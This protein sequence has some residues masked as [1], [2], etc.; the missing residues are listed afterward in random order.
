M[1]K[2]A[3]IFLLMFSFFIIGCKNQE[4]P[5]DD[6]SV[7]VT[8]LVDIPDAKDDYKYIIYGSFSDWKASSDYYLKKDNDK[9]KIEIKMSKDTNI[10]YKYGLLDGEDIRSERDIDNKVINDRKITFDK[11]K[12]VNDTVEKFDGINVSTNKDI[13]DNS[14]YDNDRG[15]V[16]TIDLND[17]IMKVDYKKQENQSWA[18]VIRNFLNDETGKL[19]EIKIEFLGEKDTEYLFKLEGGD[20][21]QEVSIIGTGSKELITI[22]VNETAINSKKFVIFGNPGKT[23]TKEEP[24]SGHYEIH[25]IILT[26]KAPDLAPIYTP[27]D[28]P[29]HILA[30]GN[31]FSDDG[32][33]LLYDILRDLGY[34]DIIIGNLYIGGCTVSTHKNNLK[35]DLSAYTYRENR[36]GSWVNRDNYKASVALEK[37]KWDFISLQQASNYSGLTNYY[38]KNDIDYIYSTAYNIA[39]IKNE[40]VKFVWQ[41]TWAYQSDSNHSAFPNYGKDQMRMYNGIIN[42]VREVIETDDF[43]PIIVP[44]GTTIQNL[45]TTFLGDTI[46]RDGY[47]LNESFGRYSASLTWAIK[48]TGK[49]IDDVKAPKSVAQKLIPLCKEAAKNA[50]IKPYEV[51]ESIYKID[52]EKQNINLDNYVLLNPSEYI[53]GNGYYNSQDSTKFLTPIQDGS[54]FCNGF[55]TTKL[56]TP[57][58]L[59]VGTVIVLDKGYQYRPEGWI[60]EAKQQNRNGNTTEEMVIVTE[61]WWGSYIYRAFNLSKVGG[62]VLTGDNY[63]NAINSFKIYLP[64]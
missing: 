61:D 46:T 15:L 29:I 35:N 18:C 44:S 34:D 12:V 32:L 43:K 22:S 1:K 13:L 51:T 8:F 45:R 10:I 4:D 21:A 19:Y 25:S 56:F 48:L 3:V 2:L 31:S 38:V 40:N 59:P 5:I 42:A 36:N 17:G 11:N 23:G 62:G 47:H 28:N 53:I 63:Q 26:L 55:I 24:L 27:G 57:N 14:F 41:M 52:E 9:Y 20:G 49:S 33:W 64:K 50:C 37:E 60:N 54:D 7:T 58:D 30:I 16:H 6:D 39:S